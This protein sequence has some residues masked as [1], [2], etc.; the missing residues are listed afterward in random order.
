MNDSLLAIQSYLEEQCSWLVFSGYQL[1]LY[2]DGK[3]DFVEGG[4]TS[5]LKSSVAV[6]RHTRFDIGS[7]TKAM[8]GTTLIAEQVATGKW[9]LDQTF[10]E[11][12]DIPERSRWGK[13][14]LET[15]M[16]HSTGLVSW[17]PLYEKT[18]REHLVEWVLSS[19]QESELFPLKPKEK[20]V[21]SDLGY[22]LFGKWLEKKEGKPLAE[23]WK[24]K[25]G[26]PLGL[27]ETTFGPC[28]G[29]VA[30][31]WISTGLLASEVFDENAR[32]FGPACCHAGLF[33]NA[34][35]L[36]QFGKAWLA[37]KYPTEFTQLRFPQLGTWALGWD[38]K[39]KTGSTAGNH[40]SEQSYGHLGYTGTSLW[41]DPKRKAIAVF[42]TN[43]VHPTRK[44]GRIQQIRPLLHDKICEYWEQL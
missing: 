6:N 20:S 23:I 27:N 35:D 21:Y 37:G 4:R 44:E 24:E 14:T 11:L 32:H 41:I 1:A 9:K 22:L 25:V 28:P 36:L 26:K 19:E 7:I 34:S 30:T 5:F 15:L 43:R 42:L 31:E 13:I 29:A 3:E 33:S 12:F 18:D 2:C 17:L 8:V 10:A 16:T 38:T 39:S 40:F